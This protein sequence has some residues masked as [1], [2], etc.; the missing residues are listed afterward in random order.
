MIG[1]SSSFWPSGLSSST[2]RT[3]ERSTGKPAAR[4]EHLDVDVVRV[5][6]RDRDA[7]DV[8]GDLRGRGV[9]IGGTEHRELVERL[10]RGGAEAVDL[11]DAVAGDPVEV[12]A[13]AQ[14]EPR[15]RA[16][17]HR[18]QHAP[19]TRLHDRD[20]H[21]PRVG[22][23]DVVGVFRDALDEELARARPAARPSGGSRGPARSSRTS[24]TPRASRPAA[25]PAS[26]TRRRPDRAAP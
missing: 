12:A 23:A 24:P 14:H 26:R 8:R 1:V 20:L 16:D 15:E 2:S 11:G 17:D 18:E 7:A 22:V 6:D 5:D 13:A 4:A 10:H 9:G 3:T 19:P 21:L 25:A